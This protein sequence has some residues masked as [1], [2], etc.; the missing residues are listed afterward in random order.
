MGDLEPY[1]IV[2]APKLLELLDAIVPDDES[3]AAARPYLTQLGLVAF[4]AK[5]DGGDLRTQLTVALK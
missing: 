5:R 1:L 4:G 2:E 3:L